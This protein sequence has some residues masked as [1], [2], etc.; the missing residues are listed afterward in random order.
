MASAFFSSDD[1]YFY[2]GALRLPDKH[3]VSRFLN[4]GTW[5]DY[6]DMLVEAPDDFDWA[7][8][9]SFPAEPHDNVTHT[10]KK[11]GSRVPQSELYDIL[12]S[13]LFG[14]E[15]FIDGYFSTVYPYSSCKEMVDEYLEDIKRS[16]V[17]VA[18][19]MIG[20][21]RLTRRGTW[22]RR[23][24]ASAA[25]DQAWADYE[26]FADEWMRSEGEFVASLIR[27]DLIASVMDGRLPAQV[28]EPSPATQHR[29]E[30]AGLGGVPL[31]YATGSLINSIRLSARI[32]GTGRW[33]TKQGIR[34]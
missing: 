13:E 30:L 33:R 12:C 10:G 34:V 4:S 25:A 14:G 24:K 21:T 23:Y 22:D 32:G 15:P 6:G 8:D 20:K 16:L 2:Q 7:I 31:L 1:E 27:D 3:D 17:D 29:R 18:E 11:Y 5:I 26:A 19:T 28:R 9:Y